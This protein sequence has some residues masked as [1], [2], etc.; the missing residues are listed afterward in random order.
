MKTRF[1]IPALLLCAALA[2]QGKSI[3]GTVKNGTTGQP[4]AGDEVI[5]IKLAASMQE[6]AKTRTDAR[7]AFT[8]TV[9]D[10]SVPHLVR[11]VHQ[12]VWYHKP[13]PPGT[14]TADVEVFDVVPKVEG[15]SATVNVMRLQAGNGQLQVTE[16]YAMKNSSKPPRTQGGPRTLDIYLPEGAE[17]ETSMA[18]GPGGMPVN[19]APVPVDGEPG[20]YYYT[21]P[22]RPGETRF[23]LTYHLPYSG[24]AELK[25]KYT[26][27]VEHLA[28]LVPKTMQF[29]ATPAGAFEA[30]PDENGVG[31]QVATNV[32]PL[33]APSFRVSGTGTM[34]PD[35][36]DNSG[37]AG[38]G[39]TNAQ[40]NR[41]GGGMA[42]PEGTPD[43]LQSYRWYVLGAFLVLL[44]AGAFW[45]TT[46]AKRAPARVAASAAPV[47]DED[48]TAEYIHRPPSA[49]KPA[50]V[51]ASRN[52]MVL[53]ALK[54]EMFRLETERLQGEVSQK[55]YEQAKA[56]LDLT[57][58][59]A[60]KR[61]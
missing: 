26:V 14:S 58:Q 49:A 22:M 59:R 29:A 24:Q 13:A 41:P 39:G 44:A 50:A 32:G 30:L 10:E 33:N 6:E 61:G 52:G 21:F 17:I 38:G 46:Q 18:A 42:N 5:L 1:A 19:S 16:M 12:K 15:L 35:E 9:Q 3:T 45:I 37:G 2:A 23:Q 31:V 28:V 47:I 7:G 25:K 20:R 54:E 34:P 53:E 55:E 8:L 60:L 11:V 43:P 40:G 36:A 4:S 27:A 57:L 56:A 48:A 51:A